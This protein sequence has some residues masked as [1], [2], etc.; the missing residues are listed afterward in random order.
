MA[1]YI[2]KSAL[3]AE[4]DRLREEKGTFYASDVLY[5]LEDFLDTLEV[6]E[7]QEDPVSDELLEKAAVE[8]F[9]QIVDLGK[10]SFLE[11]FKAGAQWQKQHLMKDAV[12]GSVCAQ[13][14]NGE[15]IVRTNFIRAGLALME[16]V[17]LII[18]KK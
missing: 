18:I 14:P 1:Q 6:K 10:N 11:I 2:D 9:K 7:V 5:N 15:V 13:R 17:K 8:A 16:K 12:D 4:I 3:V